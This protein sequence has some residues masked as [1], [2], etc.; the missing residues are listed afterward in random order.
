MSFGNKDSALEDSIVRVGQDVKS[1]EDAFVSVYQDL[2]KLK[3]ETSFKNVTSMRWR[4]IQHSSIIRYR[5]KWR[6]CQYIE[7]LANVLKTNAR[8][9]ANVKEVLDVLHLDSDGFTLLEKLGVICNVWAAYQ[10]T[11]AL[12]DI[13][14]RLKLQQSSTQVLTFDKRT[15]LL[16]KQLMTLRDALQKYQNT[17]VAHNPTPMPR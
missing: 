13:Y 7:S 3:D 14:E 2:L 17:V 6:G 11:S 9:I 15:Q 16:N 1:A 10:I 12:Q 8:P 4:P 5:T